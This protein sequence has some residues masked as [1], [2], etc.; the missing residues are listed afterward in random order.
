MRHPRRRTRP[1]ADLPPAPSGRAQG[2]TPGPRPRPHCLRARTSLLYP[3]SL[4]P[5]TLSS[6]PGPGCGPGAPR[7][8]LPP[9]GTFPGLTER[10]E[11]LD[12]GH[13][14]RFLFLG[15]NGLRKAAAG[16]GRRG[17]RSVG[18]RGGS[19]GRLLSP[20]RRLSDWDGGAVPVFTYIAAPV[21]PARCPHVQAPPTAFCPVRPGAAASNWSGS[22]DAGRRLRR[23]C[24]L[25]EGVLSTRGEM[26]GGGKG[27]F[28]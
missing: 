11:V 15:G 18:K 9:L 17:G 14:I 25:R 10:V 23:N 28:V 3:S 2:P 12:S 4:R 21:T 26:E 19:R 24:V 13:T 6:F 16:E 7:P 20:R 8:G 1:R 22:G 27:W 5:G